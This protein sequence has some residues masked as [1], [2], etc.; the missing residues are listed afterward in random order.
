MECGKETVGFLLLG[1]FI[2]NRLDLRGPEAGI[3]NDGSSVSGL[4]LQ[5]VCLSDLQ[6]LENWKV[7]HLPSLSLPI[8]CPSV[9]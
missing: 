5:N 6:V 8:F 7:L 9:T 3:G 4:K 1:Y 2:T